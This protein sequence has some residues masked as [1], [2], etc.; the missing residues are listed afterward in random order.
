MAL[1]TGPCCPGT[2][3]G[4][5]RLT[6]RRPTARLSHCTPSGTGHARPTRTVCTMLHSTLLRSGPWPAFFTASSN[7][8]PNASPTLQGTCC[9]QHHG[10]GQDSA[11]S[12]PRTPAHDVC[13]VP[14]DT[15]RRSRPALRSRA[16]SA[17]VVV[18][19]W[20]PA[21]DRTAGRSGSHLDDAFRGPGRSTPRVRVRQAP[22]RSGASTTP[23]RP[24]H[25]PLERGPEAR[26][27]TGHQQAPRW[28]SASTSPSSE[29][30]RRDEQ[31]RWG[32]SHPKPPRCS[33]SGDAN[34][35]RLP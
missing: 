6:C 4:L 12:S 34:G 23:P 15:T 20:Y 26:H 5:L 30:T 29:G 35:V 3:L 33:P 17:I 7:C 11:Q 10:R 2:R 8:S 1:L 32:G 18:P 21:G 27:G 14:R 24:F 19:P 16:Q 31:R 9:P 25:K 22:R 28:T 13:S